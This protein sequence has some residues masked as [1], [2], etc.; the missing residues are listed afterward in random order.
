MDQEGDRAQRP[1]RL[2][3]SLVTA[4]EREAHLLLRD[5]A[6]RPTGARDVDAAAE[7]L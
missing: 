2:Q 6:P 5:D 1:L 7:S 4:V 3:Q